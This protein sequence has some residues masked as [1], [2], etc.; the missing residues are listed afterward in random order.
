MSNQNENL[1]FS[2]LETESVIESEELRKATNDVLINFKHYLDNSIAA[3]KK[4][5]VSCYWKPVSQLSY[6]LK[7]NKNIYK[8]IPKSQI[9]IKNKLKGWYEIV[10][11]D[12]KP[13]SED[14]KPDIEDKVTEKK[15][16]GSRKRHELNSKENFMKKKGC[17]QIFL[18]DLENK[19]EIS[20]SD[21]QIK[22][23][24]LNIVF[25]QLD[26]IHVNSFACTVQGSSESHITF[27]GYVK[28]DS[29]IEVNGQKVDFDIIST[30]NEDKLKHLDYEKKDNGWRFVD[31]K[32]NFSPHEVTDETTK[33]LKTLTLEQLLYESKVLNADEWKLTEK[34][35]QLILEKINDSSKILREGDTLKCNKGLPLIFKIEVQPITEKWIQLIE[36][37]DGEDTTKSTLDY[38]FEDSVQLFEPNKTDKKVYFQVIGSRT[39]EC[40]LLLAPHDRKHKSNSVYPSDSEDGEIRVK[41]DINQL[42]K[43]KDAINSLMWRPNLE[44]LPLIHL[45]QYESKVTWKNF[46]ANDEHSIEWK[47]L[48]D[49]DFNGCKEQREFV[50]KAMESPDFS[51][52]D[53]PP[54]TGKTTCILELIIQ[55][56]LAK[57]RILLTASTHA[58][59]NNVLERIKDDKYL[60]Q[61]IHPL[62]IGDES[63]ALGIEEF[64]YDRLYDKHKKELGDDFTHQILVDSSN[65]VCGTTIGILRLFNEK[66]V[67]LDRGIAPFDMM[68]IDEC[69]KTTFQEF[70]VPARFAKRWVL[71]GDVRQLSPFTDREQIVAN[72]DNL[73]IEHPKNNNPAVNLSKYIQEACFLLEELRGNGNNN[74]PYAFKSLIVPVEKPVIHALDAEIQKREE[75]INKILLIEQKTNDSKKV[76]SVDEIIESPIHFYKHNLCFIDFASLEQIQD[77]I[78]ADA[79]VLAPSWERTGVAFTHER[80]RKN[81]QKFRINREEIS[82]SNSLNTELLKK[83]KTSKWSEEICWRLERVYWLRLSKKKVECY[84]DVLKRLYPKSIDTIGRITVLENIAFPSVLEALS[85]DGLVKRKKD[86][87]NTLNQGFKKEVKSDR[88]TTLT[89]QHRMHPDISAFPREQFYNNKSLCD[90]N[91]VEEERNWSY[92]EYKSRYVWLDVKGKTV[93]NSNQE[94]VNIIIKELKKF[95]DWATNNPII[96]KLEFFGVAI[97]T[98]YKGQEKILR[99]AL[100]KLPDNEKRY[101]RFKY[102]KISIKLATVDYFQGQEAD[103]V[104]LSMVN[105]YRDGFM[106]SPNRLNVSIT[107]ARYQ[108]VIVGNREYYK[109]KSRTT[110]LNE[111]AK[112]A[113]V[114]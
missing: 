111:L 14:F 47:V 94:E 44:H 53:G 10:E 37:E 98:F 97:L 33:Y 11:V 28:Y 29:V 58:A 93:K 105:T 9:K 26:K 32:P 51:I 73:M 36:K 22:I 67:I 48:K 57:K 108:L 43:Q 84:N 31:S 71:V 79:I 82:E 40:Q 62:R 109:N 88:H 60:T 85:G 3:L 103:V 87:P 55:S 96:N 24:S 45:L 100:K 5:E 20:W 91:K 64:Q 25:D 8:I 101:S 104:F 23:R 81:N 59:I 69:S 6:R 110:E 35:K 102:K 66:N 112:K 7:P 21:Y 39:E 54:G 41:V 70:L 114:Q 50:L 61:H 68:I 19:E 89:Y 49:P 13:P 12:G 38:F 34:N 95:C 17:Y 99:N 42:K 27:E 1:F 78:P 75:C 30:F 15:K 2:A 72:L 65:L 83:L 16:D 80:N 106:D 92:K 86:N 77:F 90:G 46:K 4:K 76:F 74:K 56:I 18:P 52:L 113:V 107:R 63:K